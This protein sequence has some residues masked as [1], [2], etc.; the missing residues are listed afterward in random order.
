MKAT[1]I[2]S[3]GSWYEVRTFEGKIYSCRIKGHFR[4]QNI[5]STNPICVGDFVDFILEENNPTGIIT[6]LYPRKNSIVRKSVNLS[7]KMHIL[8]SNIDMVFLIITIQNPMTSFVFIDRFL[9]AAASYKI[10]VILLF[11]KTDTLT[12]DAKILQK[13]YIKI[14]KNIGYDCFAISALQKT[15]LEEIKKILKDKITLFS[16]HSGVGKST[17]INALANIS[18]QTAPLSSYH[19]QGVHTTTFAK[20]YSLSFG[21]SVVD[22]PGIK[23]FG[24]VD[25]EKFEIPDYFKEFFALKPFC[26]FYNCKHLNE[27][28][29]AV[30]KAL[31][32]GKI[33]QT[34]YESYL[35]ILQTSAAAF[36]I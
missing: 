28:K 29:C 26:K 30:K 36:R 1:I 12:F 15:N 10:P 19:N 34:R 3:T 17:L 8:A 4:M 35:Q 27:P 21:G 7:K 5:Q 14:Y 18:L 2:K 22:S 32:D 33:A 25:I 6:K 9:V 24:I 11:N 20:M 23:G 31:Q 13:K 16:G